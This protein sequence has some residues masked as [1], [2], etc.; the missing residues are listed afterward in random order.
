[1]PA[2][3]R[4]VSPGIF[5]SPNRT[6]WGFYQT[7]ARSTTFGVCSGANFCVENPIPVP[8]KVS[9]TPGGIALAGT[10]PVTVWLAGQRLPGTVSAGVTFDIPANFPYRGY[11]PVQFEINGVR[12]NIAFVHLLDEGI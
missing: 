3:Q 9:I 1:M 2:G 7:P 8:A 12:S 10:R 4:P 6:A 5:V 11:V